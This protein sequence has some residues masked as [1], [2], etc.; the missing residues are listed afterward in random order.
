MINDYISLEQF[1]V[2]GFFKK[3]TPIKTTQFISRAEK[4]KVDKATRKERRLTEKIEA[5]LKSKKKEAKKDST[6]VIGSDGKAQSD[7][8]SQK[9]K[10]LERPV[11]VPAA[12]ESEE[13]EE[14]PVCY[15]TI[16]PININFLFVF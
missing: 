10:T 11:E 2:P 4:E 3:T 5:I 15:D 9:K 12:E 16:F 14:L 7:E 13:F 8:A 1:I 6:I